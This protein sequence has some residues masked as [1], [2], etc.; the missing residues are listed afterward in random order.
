M[1]NS[2]LSEKLQ[3]KIESKFLTITGVLVALL[4]APA[5]ISLLKEPTKADVVLVNSSR[6]PASVVDTNIETEP[7]P[8]SQTSLVKYDCK[9]TATTSELRS[10]FVRFSGVPCLN[11]KDI[12]ITNTTNGFS[13]SVIFTKNQK[14]TTDFIELK[15]GENNLEIT[16]TQNDGAKTSKIFKVLRRMPASFSH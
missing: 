5:F 15:E 11:T 10:N 7:A 3:A 16:T 2:A 1:K 6:A 4:G 12:E 13:A 8:S 9:S 14:F